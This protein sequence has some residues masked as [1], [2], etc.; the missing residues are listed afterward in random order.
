MLVSELIRKLVNINRP[1]S[2]VIIDS[3]TC[4][5]EFDEVTEVISLDEVCLHGNKEL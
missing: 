2:K 5:D 3:R 4:G 1:N